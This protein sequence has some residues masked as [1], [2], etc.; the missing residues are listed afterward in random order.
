MPLPGPPPPPLAVL[1]PMVS[2]RFQNRCRRLSDHGDQVVKR[3]IPP[4]LRVPFELFGLVQRPAMV[5]LEFVPSGD[6]DSQFAVAVI[7]RLDPTAL[8]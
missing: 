4:P 2:R 7:L 5:P 6:E 8:R 3:T 1:V